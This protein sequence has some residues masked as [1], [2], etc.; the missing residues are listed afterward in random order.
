MDGRVFDSHN[1]RNNAVPVFSGT[2]S[3]GG[4]G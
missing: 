1:K 3:G 2:F 4:A